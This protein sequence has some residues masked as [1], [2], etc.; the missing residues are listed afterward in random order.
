MIRMAR[1]TPGPRSPAAAR[2]CSSVSS[3]PGGSVHGSEDT[4][5]SAAVGTVHDTVRFGRRRRLVVEPLDPDR[6]GPA[7]DARDASPSGSGPRPCRRDRSGPPPRPG[8]DPVRRIAS[9]SGG[10]GAASAGSSTSRRRPRMRSRKPASPQ[11]PRTAIA[12]SD[13][14]VAVTWDEAA[15]AAGA[16]PVPGPE[17]AARWTDAEA[18]PAAP[19]TSAAARPDGPANLAW[20]RGVRGAGIGRWAPSRIGDPTSSGGHPMCGACNSGPRTA[21]VRSSP[22]V[23]FEDAPPGPRA[24]A[25]MHVP[26][27]PR[28]FR[29]SSA[30]AADSAGSIVV[31]R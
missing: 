12:P 5:G 20:I 30:G 17:T 3:R 7:I 24:G 26:P 14:S 15:A 9:R 27:G 1:S 23:R 2:A 29:T 28:Y 16:Q 21:M 10:A 25:P 19:S 4:R 11:A 31:D 8:P 13:E 22:R 6:S 18:G